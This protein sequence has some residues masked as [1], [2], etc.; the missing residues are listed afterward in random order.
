MNGTILLYSWGA[1]ISCYSGKRV[2]V[3]EEYKNP[4][5]EA[6]AALIYASN[7]TEDKNTEKNEV[8]SLLEGGRSHS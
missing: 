5:S 4:Q 3:P 7:K 2:K 1:F 6:E 8:K